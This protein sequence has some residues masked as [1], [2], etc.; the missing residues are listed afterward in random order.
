MLN[1][2]SKRLGSIFDALRSRGTLS[3]QDIL[4]SLREIRIA[5]LEADVAL[6]TVRALL[7]SVKEKAIGHDVLKS[8][9]PGQ[10]VV[11]IV[12]DCLVDLLS[13][14]TNTPRDFIPPFPLSFNA[15]APIVVMMVGLQG[16][17]KT[18][19]T[20]KIAKLLTDKHHKKVLM[21][22]LDI[23]RPAAQKQLSILGEQ[24]KVNTL[25]IIDGQNVEAIA[26]RALKDAKLQGFDIVLLDTAGRLHLDDELMDELIQVKKIT[27]PF[28]IILVADAMTGQDS[29]K[30]A[31]SFHNKINVTNIM[32]TRFDGDGRGGAALSMRHMTQCPISFIGRGE[33]IDEIEIFQPHRIADRIFD[34]GD[35]V[36]LVEKATQL[37]Q[38]A[39]SIKMAQ[40]MQ[41]G[42][43]DLGDMEK[44]M[45]QMI[46][47]GG[48]QG[49]MGML[50]G[51]GK[52][53]EKVAEHLPQGDKVIHRQ[54]AI[55]RSM[56]PMER[57]NPDI[58]N[59][60]R[61]RRIAKGAG[62]DVSDLNRLLKQ[63]QQMRD[64]MKK[65]NKGSLFKGGLSSIKDLFKSH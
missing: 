25:P 31:E 13:G 64:M 26:A 30:I 27:N 42:I 60:S 28:H 39:D 4:N 19:S 32:L 20:A 40:K 59:A 53:K 51:M 56:T 2:L 33:K 14:E 45:L 41:K 21:A 36:D 48:M 58:L 15:P 12:Y 6:P 1:S 52:L 34:Q 8:V 37:A 43:F 17:G 49:I 62:M 18:T 54:I 38:D 47:F 61:K 11:K 63:Y 55:I 7:D 46:K 65:L 3:E 23:Y 50:P 10:M 29:V 24:I 57:R 22:S 35:V 16:S 44:Q 5:L 9:T